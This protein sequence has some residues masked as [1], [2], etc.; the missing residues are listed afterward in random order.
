MYLC[1]L[2]S[3]LSSRLGMGS[4]SL[5]PSASSLWGRGRG[6][7]PR[8]PQSQALTCPWSA[9]FTSFTQ[10]LS[11]SLYIFNSFLDGLWRTARWQFYF[12]FVTAR[13]S[14]FLSGFFSR[15]WFYKSLW[16]CSRCVLVFQPPVLMQ[17]EPVMDMS[18]FQAFK[19][20]IK[21][22]FINSNVLSIE[23]KLKLGIGIW[24]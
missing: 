1:I 11:G 12:I 14:F 8:G 15:A 18:R 6:F 13:R 20:V 10:A 3:T 2:N 7:S 24:Y 9:R 21:E 4:S 22:Y 17:C 19:K 5:C 16:Q 23:S